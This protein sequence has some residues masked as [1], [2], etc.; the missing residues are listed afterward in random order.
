MGLGTAQWLERTLEDCAKDERNDF[1]TSIRE[2]YQS[3]IAQ[4]CSNNHG[5]FLEVAVYGDGGHQNFIL[6]PE[7]EGGRG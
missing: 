2:G 6:I 1:Y 5:R 4:R 3:V 7:E